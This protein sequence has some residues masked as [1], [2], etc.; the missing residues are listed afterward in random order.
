METR[1]GGGHPEEIEKRQD[2]DI[3]HPDA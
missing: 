3:F 1:L 2:V